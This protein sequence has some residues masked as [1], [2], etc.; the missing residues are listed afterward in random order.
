MLTCFNVQKTHYFSNTVHCCG[1]SDWPAD[2]VLCDWQNTTSACRKC[3]APFHNRQLQ[4]SKVNIKTVNNGLSFTIS[5]S[6]RVQQS[7]LTDTV[8][9][10]VYVYKQ[11]AIKKADLRKLKAVMW[12]CFSLSHTHTHKSRNSTLLKGQW[13]VLKLITKHI[14]SH[15]FRS[16]RLSEPIWNDPVFFFFFFFFFFI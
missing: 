16:A 3:N 13:Q 10:L 2:P 9:K 5:S 1:S 8:M 15:W 4:L 7:C 6:P 12:P 11:A 14:S